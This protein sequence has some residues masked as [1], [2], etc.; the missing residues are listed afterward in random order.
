MLNIEAIYQRATHSH[1]I[2]FVCFLT[3]SGFLILNNCMSIDIQ[4]FKIKIIHFKIV[5]K[6]MLLTSLTY[7]GQISIIITH[8]L[9]S[10][11][12]N[13]SRTRT[14]VVMLCYYIDVTKCVGMKITFT[15]C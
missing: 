15:R 13:I 2:A 11:K 8:H 9:K 10:H 1:R 6:L 4:L 14:I 5:I 7:L 3:R 12:P